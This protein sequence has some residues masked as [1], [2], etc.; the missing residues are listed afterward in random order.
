MSKFDEWNFYRRQFQ[1]I[2]KGVKAVD[3]LAVAPNRCLWQIEIK[4]YRQYR[5]TKTIDLAQEIAIKVRNSLA[6]L[7]AAKVNTNDVNEKQMAKAA[8]LC[9]KLR[10]V[11][12]LEQ[13]ISHSKLFPRVI[14]PAKVQQSLKQLMKSVDPHPLVLEKNRMNDVDWT[15]S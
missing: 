14:D 1:K 8:L 5:R 15:V 4:D 11:L 13:P 6:A 10:I 9:R 12:H 7:V 3:I 2:G